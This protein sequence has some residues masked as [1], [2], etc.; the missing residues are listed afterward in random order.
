MSLTSLTARAVYDPIGCA[1]EILDGADRHDF[2]TR[3]MARALGV[4]YPTLLRV[5][6]RLDLR[7][8]I[9]DK[10]LKRRTEKREAGK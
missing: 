7:A 10:W 8:L 3:P 2:E 4:S 5:L 6:G 1:E 9:R